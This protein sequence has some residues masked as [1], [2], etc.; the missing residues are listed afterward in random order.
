MPTGNPPA[1]EQ[2]PMA[3]HQCHQHAISEPGTRGT[4]S[5]R[6]TGVDARRLDHGKCSQRQRVMRGTV[7]RCDVRNGNTFAAIS[8][9]RSGLKRFS[10]SAI[11]VLATARSTA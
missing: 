3:C 11:S 2:T 1:W 9:R 4:R 5:L 7:S 10:F 8:T 6:T